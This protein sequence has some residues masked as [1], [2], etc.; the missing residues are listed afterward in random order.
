MVKYAF[1]I[2][3]AV[4]IAVSENSLNPAQM[5]KDIRLKLIPMLFKVIG[6]DNAKKL[7]DEVINI[8]RLGLS[9]GN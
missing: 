5:E 8:T 6:M 7:A 4:N 3:E 2:D 9:R 1:D